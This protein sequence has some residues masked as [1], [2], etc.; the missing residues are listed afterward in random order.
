MVKGGGLHLSMPYRHYFFSYHKF[1]LQIEWL[2]AYNAS[3][4]YN[5][6]LFL[7]LFS[8]SH[9][10]HTPTVKTGAEHFTFYALSVGITMEE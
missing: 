4:M 6:E 7:V 10:L 2:L 9:N 8:K 3:V 1:F 5:T